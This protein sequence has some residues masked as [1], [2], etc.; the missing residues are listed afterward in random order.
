[1]IKDFKSHILQI[2]LDGK[3][4]CNIDILFN[5][6]ILILQLLIVGDIIPPKYGASVIVGRS[7]L[8][9]LGKIDGNAFPVKE[10]P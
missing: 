7:I 2:S 3:L 8:H 10:V 5:S 4:P 6:S 9:S 1:M